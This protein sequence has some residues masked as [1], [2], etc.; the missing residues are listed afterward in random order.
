M[1]TSDHK[2]KRAVLIPDP[3]FRDEEYVRPFYTL[4]EEGFTVDVA[5]QDKL[6]V[7]GMGGTAAQAT[8]DIRALHE[9]DYDL[10]VY[11]SG[12]ERLQSKPI[13]LAIDRFIREMYRQGKVVHPTDILSISLKTGQTRGIFKR[14]PGMLT[15][16]R[17]QYD[18]SP[19][20]TRL[21]KEHDHDSK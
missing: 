11:A 18:L 12:D 3:G 1:N 20:T 9:D 21:S 15:T 19:S 6:T 10:V 4:L 8:V 13:N 14:V 16:G 17:V 7:Y 5:A 2:T